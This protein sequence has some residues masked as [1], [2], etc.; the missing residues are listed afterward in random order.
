MA[1][2]TLEA[3]L[4]QLQFMSAP[5]ALA[6]WGERHP[7]ERAVVRTALEGLVDGELTRRSEQK[8]AAR[9]KAAKFVQ[10]QTVD[11]FNFE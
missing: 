5:A 1:T 7:G 10:V 4:L 2:L 9:I 3:K 6:A 8:V 11:S